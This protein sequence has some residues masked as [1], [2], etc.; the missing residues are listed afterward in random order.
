MVGL[1]LLLWPTL[2]MG[3]DA[4]ALLRLGIEA[5]G[6]ADFKGSIRSLEKGAVKTTDTGVLAKIHFYLG[7][8]LVELGKKDA[9]R[10][11]FQRAVE[12]A[13]EMDLEAGE[14]KPGVV[15]A[16]R[17]VR[18]SRVGLLLLSLGPAGGSV[19]I[20]GKPLGRVPPGGLPL[21][22][23]PHRLEVRR[24]GAAPQRRQVEIGAIQDPSPEQF[25]RIQEGH[26]LETKVEMAV[27]VSRPKTLRPTPAAPN[28]S[29]AEDPKRRPKTILGFSSLA[30]A[31]AAAAGAGTLYG[32]GISR[33]EEAHDL[34]RGTKVPEEAAA[35]REDVEAAQGLVTGGHVLAGVAAA[36][37]GFTFYELATRPDRNDG[38]SRRPT[39]RAG[40]LMAPGSAGAMVKVSF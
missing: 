5:Y 28:D 26:L 17:L 37:L 14:H 23:G 24:K 4:A 21:L 1:Y 12:M 40:L 13:P 38:G 2:A 19:Y 36:A 16:F 22:Q 10:A 6:L 8:N 9:A 29:D 3:Q 34:Y 32:L 25:T 30:L 7:C 33:G 11:S 20:D 18:A 39:A 35:H 15:E 27:A 31:L